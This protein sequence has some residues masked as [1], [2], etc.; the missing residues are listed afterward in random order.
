MSET[1]IAKTTIGA[2]VGIAKESTNGARTG[3]L[4]GIG[5]GPG[6]PELL[7]F[8]AARLIEQ[9][10]VVSYIQNPEGHSL[11]R[12]IAAEHIQS[13]HIELPIVYRMSRDRGKINAAYDQA[14]TAIK[15]HLKQGHDVAMLCEGDPLFY[16]SFNY[17]LERL[18]VDFPCEVVPGINSVQAVAAATQAPLIMQ[19]QTL[20]VVSARNADSRILQALSTHDSIAILKAGP[21][22]PRLMALLKQSGRWHH[23][24]YVTRATQTNEVVY[25]TL[26]ELPAETGDYFGLMLIRPEQKQV[27]SQITQEKPVIVS[28]TDQGKKL[29]EQLN[30]TIDAEHW[31]QPQPFQAKV[32]EAFTQGRR[33]I[34]ICA[35][36]IAMR[37]LAP[38]IKDK[39]TDPAV[40]VLD[41]QGQF[42]IPLLSGHEGGAN[43]WAD[44]VAKITQGQAAITSARQYLNPTWIV[45]MGCERNCPVSVLKGLL[46]EALVSAKLNM[47]DIAAICSIDVKADEVGLMA[48]AE[49]L[50]LPFITYPAT[51]LR[52][53]EDQLQNPSDIVFKEVGCYGVAEGAALFHAAQLSATNESELIL[54]KQKNTQAT[55]AIARAYLEKAH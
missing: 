15:Q 36:G 16:G 38:V 7:T 44:D 22:R 11:G 54:P 52:S 2:T 13:S 9:S 48:L 17:L 35:T 3:T 45:G 55:V 23:A 37:T 34:L 27:E 33:L 1:T 10:A 53:V 18:K 12:E 39:L 43:Q 19:N 25:H 6:D 31:H 46:A 49:S 32:R 40:L 29:A 21:H 24:C 5:I 41:E 28:L 14:A 51:D 50:G 47:E 26:D 30:E 20:A 4:F 42:V 8:K